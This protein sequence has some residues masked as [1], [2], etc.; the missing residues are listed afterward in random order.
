MT[1]HP[2]LYF[3]PLPRTN[4][5]ID[6]P[7]TSNLYTNFLSTNLSN[8]SEIEQGSIL[9][10]D[11]KQ[12]E[13]GCFKGLKCR[14][15]VSSRRRQ[16]CRRRLNRLMYFMRVF[17]T[18]LFSTTGLCFL[19]VIYSCLGATIFVF[20]ESQNEKQVRD[21]MNSEHVKCASDLWNYTLELNLLYPE[22]WKQKAIERIQNFEKMIINAVHND[23]YGSG[24]DQWSFSGALLYSV[25]VI[26]TI[27]E[28]TIKV[29]LYGT[30]RPTVIK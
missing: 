29:T 27:G 4:S 25:T 28:F 24:V 16:N 15:T 11:S 13:K 9:P 18:H 30:L 5:T 6:F 3:K 17:L 23:G 12:K 8:L 22:L 20:L 19:V 26:T 1:F 2:F 21:N 14:L 7:E 10:L